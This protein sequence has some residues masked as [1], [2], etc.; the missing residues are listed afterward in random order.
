VGN[1]DRR[2]PP[3][4]V[5]QVEVLEL[6]ASDRI[7]RSKWLIEQQ[8]SRAIREYRSERESLTLTAG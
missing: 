7:E 4:H 5:P 1:K 6:P 8:E 2:Y 3:R